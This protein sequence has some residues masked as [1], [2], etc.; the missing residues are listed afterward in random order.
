[1]NVTIRQWIEM[2]NLLPNRRELIRK[3]PEFEPEYLEWLEETRPEHKETMYKYFD[4][5]SSAFKA[6]VNIIIDDVD[7]KIERETEKAV[8]LI[9]DGKTR[10]VPKSWLD[11]ETISTE[12]FR[13]KFM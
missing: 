2:W 10:W 11:G 13:E 9:C 6:K 3:Y 5:L 8:L 7:L 1:M 12:K 4:G